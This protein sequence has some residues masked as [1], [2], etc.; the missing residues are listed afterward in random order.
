MERKPQPDQIIIAKCIINLISYMWF[1]YDVI[2]S[3]VKRCLNQNLLWHIVPANKIC[4]NSWTMMIYATEVK[5]KRQ[6]LTTKCSY[7]SFE[8]HNQMCRL[9]LNM[10][11]ERFSHVLIHNMKMI[12]LCFATFPHVRSRQYGGKWTHKKPSDMLNDYQ[13]DEMLQKKTQTISSCVSHVNFL[14]KSW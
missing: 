11:W 7:R 4:G 8:L 10:S 14:L 12:R 5:K 2:D 13:T 9:Y 6:W 1:P 3:F